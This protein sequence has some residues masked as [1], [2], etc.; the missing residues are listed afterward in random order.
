[1]THSRVVR[2]GIELMDDDHGR[3]DELIDRAASSPDAEVADIYARVADELRAHFSR[4]EELMREREV[5]GLDCHVA[6]HRFLLEQ[7]GQ[8]AALPPSDLR[9]HLHAVI[10]Q[11]I[12][13]HI[14]TLD[15]L[16][17]GYMRGEIGRSDF[18]K[19]RLPL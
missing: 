19:L 12:S 17:A 13:S 3:I 11:L 10:G 9:R 6:Q 1:M 15:R 7:V 16:A 18:E 4:E 8:H 2:L 14:V 5:P